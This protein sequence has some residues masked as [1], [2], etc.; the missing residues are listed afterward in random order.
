MFQ[1]PWAHKAICVHTQ[2]AVHFFHLPR[3]HDLPANAFTGGAGRSYAC[4]QV[5]HDTV[6]R[7]AAKAVSRNTHG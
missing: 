7:M 3:L 1:V 4:M 5:P 6:A 2:M